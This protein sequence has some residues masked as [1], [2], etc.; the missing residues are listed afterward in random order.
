LLLNDND[1]DIIHTIIC[2]F[3]RMPGSTLKPKSK[4]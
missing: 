4:I 3:G 2:I 1:D